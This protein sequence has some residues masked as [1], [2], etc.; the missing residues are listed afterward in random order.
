MVCG[1]LRAGSY[2][3]SRARTIEDLKHWESSSLTQIPSG[4]LTPTYP[5][6][7]TLD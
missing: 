6:S 7:L 5:S 3:I 4:F 2:L 1:M